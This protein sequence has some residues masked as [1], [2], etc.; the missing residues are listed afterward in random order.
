MTKKE[1]CKTLQDFINKYNE[2]LLIVCNGSD[3]YY[4]YYNDIININVY[5]ADEVDEMFTEVCKTLG[6]EWECP[7]FLMSLLH[8]FGHAQTIDE[9]D[10]FEWNLVDIYVKLKGIM[11]EKIVDKDYFTYF[12]S[13]R[14]KVATEYACAFANEHKT[15]LE[16]LWK[17]LNGEH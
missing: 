1:V 8:E 13:P 14:E 12:Y 2:D 11:S 9:C 4:D 17:T 7:I 16:D 5:H 15:E 6:L 10:T 3:W